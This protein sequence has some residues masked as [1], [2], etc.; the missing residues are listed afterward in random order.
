VL[1]ALNLSRI[2]SETRSSS[3]NTDYQCQKHEIER[4]EDDGGRNEWDGKN[5]ISDLIQ[6]VNPGALERFEDYGSRLN[7]GKSCVSPS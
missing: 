1:N 5:E 6:Q 7:L 4:Y 3:Q 2:V